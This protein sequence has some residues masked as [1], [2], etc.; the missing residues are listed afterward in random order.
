MADYAAG[1]VAVIV[2]L[3]ESFTVCEASLVLT[4]VFVVDLM[5]T[6][7][8]G[9]ST[10]FRCSSVLKSALAAFPDLVVASAVDV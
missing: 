6:S 5:T 7:D 8:V 2:N 3:T 9:F 4:E 1:F 10:D